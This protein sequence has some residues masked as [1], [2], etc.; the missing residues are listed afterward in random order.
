MFFLSY[1]PDEGVGTIKYSV[2]FFARE[3]VNEV[4]SFQM[5]DQLR[6]KHQLWAI[7]ALSF[8]DL[9]TTLILCVIMICASE[10]AL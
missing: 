7:W 5:N 3:G 1:M 2:T 9:G 6:V 4:L 8:L 10:Y